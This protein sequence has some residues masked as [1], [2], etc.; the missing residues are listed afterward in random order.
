QPTISASAVATNRPRSFSACTTILPDLAPAAMP[1]PGARASGR[2]LWSQRPPQPHELADQATDLRGRRSDGRELAD[3]DPARQVARADDDP[4]TDGPQVDVVGDLLEPL[5]R[6]RARGLQRAPCRDPAVARRRR[7]RVVLQ[8]RIEDRI[9]QFLVRHVPGQSR[10]GAGLPDAGRGG[11][12]VAIL[13]VGV[14]HR[15]QLL[16]TRIAQHRVDRLAAID[17]RTSPEVRIP[18]WWWKQRGRGWSGV[19]HASGSSLKSRP[20]M[21]LAWRARQAG[22]P[23]G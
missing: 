10:H 2:G 20:W 16:D 9:P 23:E 8:Q 7:M 14:H 11:D 21:A 13:A 15:P 5:P 18:S 6:P 12:E 1:L 22:R 19:V 17:D 4:R 3:E